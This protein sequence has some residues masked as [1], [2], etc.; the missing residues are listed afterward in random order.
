MVKEAI[1]AWIAEGGCGATGGF[2]SRLNE[3]L[4]RTI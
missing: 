1:T 3:L 4:S 2:K